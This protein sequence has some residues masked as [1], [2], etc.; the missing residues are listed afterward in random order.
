MKLYNLDEHRPY[1]YKESLKGLSKLLPSELR[2]W[3]QV[4]TIVM[5]PMAGCLLKLMRGKTHFLFLYA[6][7]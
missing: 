2:I 7:Q 6:L 1:G 5:I 4:G 3:L